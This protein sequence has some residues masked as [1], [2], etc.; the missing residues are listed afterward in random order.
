VPDDDDRLRDASGAADAGWSEPE[1]ADATWAD[2]A[3]PDDISELAKDIAAYHREARANRRRAVVDR[4]IA[5]HSAAPL[6]LTLAALAVIAIVATVLTAAHRPQRAVAAPLATSVAATGHVGDLLPPV[7]LQP[8][9]TGTATRGSQTLRPG[10]VAVMPPRCGCVDT[11]V[12]QA[13]LADG[14]QT[15][16]YAVAA[17]PSADADALT[18]QLRRGGVYVDESGVLASSVGARTLTLV[19]VEGDGKIVGVVPDATAL[20]SYALR[21]RLLSLRDL[22]TAG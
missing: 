6:T 5:R 22:E 2:V 20:S 13:A 15:N 19:L 18:G 9:G 3:A 21:E 16:Y 1:T 10:V 4:Y 17:G 11:L 14:V 8:A 12:R 7:T